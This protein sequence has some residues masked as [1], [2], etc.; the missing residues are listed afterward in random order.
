MRTT[1][2]PA[3][4]VL[5]LFISGDP[6]ARAAS[7]AEVDRILALDRIPG[8]ASGMSVA[9]QGDTAV[10][11]AARR[12]MWPYYE[13]GQCHVYDR[14]DG[15]WT[16]AQILAP[17][18]PVYG[19]RFGQSVAIDGNVVVIGAP[20][21]CCP[22]STDPGRAFVFRRVD[23]SWSEEA[24]LLP[25]NGE[26]DDFFGTAV[27]LR[28]DVIAVGA[29]GDDE[30][31]FRSGAAYLF[32]RSGSSWPLETKLVD[33]AN[34]S[35]GAVGQSV[36]FVSDVEIVVG[37]A[38]GVLDFQYGNKGWQLKQFIDP[39]APGFGYGLATDGTRLV[40]GS[41]EEDA[42]GV[43]S[44]RLYLYQKQ[45]ANWSLVQSITPLDA[46]GRLGWKI[47]V[48]G[49]TIVSGA[50]GHGTSAGANVGA[51]YVF[52]P[53]SGV[54]GQAQRLAGSAS[55]PGDQFG[56]AVSL[57]AGTLFVGAPEADEGGYINTGE[58]YVF[59]ETAS[60][61]P[62][63]ADAGPDSTAACGG[64]V[65]LDGSASTDPDSTPG[66]NDDIVAFDWFEGATSLGQGEVLSVG[67]PLGA[68]TITL[69]VTDTTGATDTDDV[70]VT[71][72][73]AV[74][75][76]LTVTLEPSTLWPPNHRLV[77]VTATLTSTGMCGASSIVLESLTS[78]E[79]DDAPG[80]ADGATTGDIDGAGVGTDDRR[81]RL[82]AERAAHGNGRT[83]TATYRATDESGATAVGSATVFVPV[84]QGGVTDPIVL[85]LTGTA[86]GTRVDWTAV[87]GSAVY[88]VARTRLT[89]IVDT[90][91]AFALGNVSCLESRSSDT[92]T[93]G[94]EDPVTPAAG[95]AFV[96]VVEYDDGDRVSYGAESAVKPRIAGSGDCP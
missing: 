79:P 23:G 21:D 19:G 34:R 44:G 56:R 12:G 2:A 89:E 85:T 7:F 58:A 65:T 16:F 20:A 49:S 53:T 52:R 87:G 93:A 37:S 86:A 10:V 84:D 92:T 15:A 26:D 91:A 40:V 13:W 11:C 8:D 57:D 9:V 68:H 39:P 55:V 66:T 3:L 61:D 82:R 5:T 38:G 80:G 67:L 48:Q 36:A 24:M 76:A 33:G 71:V 32:R 72:V 62:P 75:P 90:G 64:L 14:I 47:A 95:E 41:P 70:V 1:F 69:R 30:I 46:G 22:E 42:T 31:G 6:S 18:G 25:V 4:A 35:Y 60:N 54:W 27:A 28:G 74:P 73:S 45:G 94:F 51:A 29:S 78:D 88:N 43:D 17:S 50:Y 77:D 83:Y 59:Q 96:Y 81:F 63:H